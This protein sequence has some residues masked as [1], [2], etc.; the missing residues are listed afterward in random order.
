[1]HNNSIRKDNRL[2]VNSNN[3]SSL[4]VYKNQYS[5]NTKYNFC[6]VTGKEYV[7]KV[8]ALYWSLNK[9]SDRFHLWIC[10][11]DDVTYSTITSLKLNH[12]TAF[13]VSDIE[14][15]Q[16]LSIKTKRKTNEYC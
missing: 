6:T 16:L 1:M 5:Y 14:D 7:F 2:L 4:D 11:I 13:M 12:L 15:R 9:H 8:L 3:N 10:C